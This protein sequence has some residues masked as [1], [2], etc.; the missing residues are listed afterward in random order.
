VNSSTTSPC[1]EVD[2]LPRARE[3][4]SSVSART[5]FVLPFL[6]KKIVPSNFFLLCRGCISY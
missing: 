6:T 1:N 3:I 5:T 4:T 2:D